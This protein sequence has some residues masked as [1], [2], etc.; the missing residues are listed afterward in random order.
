M[1]ARGM[2]IE[3]GN[4]ISFPFENFVAQLSMCLGSYSSTC[5]KL[6]LMLAS[7]I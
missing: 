3:A 7:G 1:T 6:L 4:V 2:L 5:S